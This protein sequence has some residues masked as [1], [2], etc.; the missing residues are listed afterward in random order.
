MITQINGGGKTVRGYKIGHWKFSNN[1]W[2][3]NSISFIYDEIT[4]PEYGTC[5]L[6]PDERIIGVIYRKHPTMDCFI[7]LDFLIARLK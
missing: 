7:N 6:E 3:V 1:Y 4:K 5:K 2:A